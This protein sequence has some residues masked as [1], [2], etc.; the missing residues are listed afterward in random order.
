MARY[1]KDANRKL[2][3][4]RVFIIPHGGNTNEESSTVTRVEFEKGHS[5]KFLKNEMRK[6]LKALGLNRDQQ[7][8]YLKQAFNNFEDE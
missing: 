7:R 5:I 4:A 1:K 2:N 6:V 8:Q 3:T